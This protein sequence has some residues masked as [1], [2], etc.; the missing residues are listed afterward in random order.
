MTVALSAPNSVWLKEYY[1]QI[2]MFTAIQGRPIQARVTILKR[3]HLEAR[4]MRESRNQRAYPLRGTDISLKA[5]SV[6][7]AVG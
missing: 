3:L 7:R 2:S 6:L 5:W 4:K 1:P